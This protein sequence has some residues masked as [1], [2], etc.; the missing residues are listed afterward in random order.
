MVL[1]VAERGQAESSIGG[2]LYEAGLPCK[3]AANWI[4]GQNRGQVVAF[5]SLAIEL[6]EMAEFC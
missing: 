5:V 6:A 3:F 2:T 4:G 1:L